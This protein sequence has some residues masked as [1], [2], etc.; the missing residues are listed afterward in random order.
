MVAVFTGVVWLAVLSEF[1]NKVTIVGFYRSSRRDIS[2]LG[3]RLLASEAGLCFMGLL[4][5]E[6][7]V[8]THPITLLY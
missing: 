2:C 4:E 7:T 3:E 6:L 5:T 1:E 8:V